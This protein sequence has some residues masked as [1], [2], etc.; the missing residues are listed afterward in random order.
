MLLLELQMLS[1][2]EFVTGV[3]FQF[4]PLYSTLFYFL[5]ILHMAQRYT[6]M[7]NRNPTF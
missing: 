7:V 4:R 5:I 6:T 1:N 2:Y 3:F